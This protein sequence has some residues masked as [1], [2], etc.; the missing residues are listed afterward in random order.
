MPG[1]LIAM[2]K[3]PEELGYFNEIVCPSPY[4]ID[5]S[6]TLSPKERY[7][8]IF[9]LLYLLEVCQE[10]GIWNTLRVSDWEHGGQGSP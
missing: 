6:L 5:I 8:E 3:P 7:L 9:M 2:Y 10:G 4:M 1:V